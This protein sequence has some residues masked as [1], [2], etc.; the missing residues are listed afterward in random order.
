MLHPRGSLPRY[1]DKIGNDALEVLRLPHFGVG[2]GTSVNF[3]RLFFLLRVLYGER[4]V[5]VTQEV[6]S[7][8]GRALPGTPVPFFSHNTTSSSENG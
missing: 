5:R 6:L 3:T 4:L 2:D 8:F 7:F 1:S